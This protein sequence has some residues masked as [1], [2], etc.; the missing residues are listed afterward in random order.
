MNK[1]L[2]IG[3]YKFKNEVEYFEYVVEKYFRKIPPIPTNVYLNQSSA[4]DYENRTKLASICH[5]PSII[6]TL[7]RDENYHVRDAARKNEFWVLVGQ[8]QDVLG[9]EKR[10][11]RE[12]ARQEVFRIIVVMLMFEDDLDVLREVLR[13]ASVSTRMLTRYIEYLEKRSHGKRD[14][15]ILSE[16]RNIL[17]EKKQRI[18]KV[19]NLQKA[20]KNINDQKNQELIVNILADVDHVMRKAV[21]NLL[22]D[23]DPVIFYHMVQAAIT[24]SYQDDILS[25][26]TVFTELIFVVSRR[27]DLRLIKVKEFKTNDPIDEE[28]SG[29][30]LKQYIIQ[31]LT[32]QRLELLDRC[33][34]DLTDF[35][36]IQLLTTCIS[37]SDAKIRKVAENIISLDDIFALVNDVS[38][39]QNIFKSILTILSDHPDEQVQKRVS[40]TYL[41]ESERLR[42]KLKELEQSIT[43]YFDIIFNS[44]YLISI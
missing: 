13:N 2:E 14:E 27:D 15:L 31:L 28:L 41:E 39:P 18:V 33:Q 12:F 3:T 4:S 36:N 19:A 1:L 38:T 40:T 43:A 16:A 30:N 21:H 9:F 23:I 8:L 6:N 5:F 37:D 20:R 10:E 32:R 26:F 22:Q 7:A 35:Q 25:K 42:N 24:K 11:R 34:D 29:K 17:T 44:V